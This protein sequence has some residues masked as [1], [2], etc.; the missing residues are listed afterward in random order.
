MS[1]CSAAAQVPWIKEKH[2]DYMKLS[3]TVHEV[4]QPSMLSLMMPE[5]SWIHAMGYS[6]ENIGNGLLSSASLAK[7]LAKCLSN[8]AF[9]IL[10]VYLQVL[11]VFFIRRDLAAQRLDFGT[12][13][14]LDAEARSVAREVIAPVSGGITDPERLVLRIRQESLHQP[15]CFPSFPLPGVTLQ[16]HVTGGAIHRDFLRRYC[17]NF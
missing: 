5:L 2:G 1:N 17:L 15:R 12:V 6:C 9:S 16:Q 13:V 4:R 10:F 14:C 7:R 8:F 11:K 3:D